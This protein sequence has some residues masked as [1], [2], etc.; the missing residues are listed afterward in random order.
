MLIDILLFVCAYLLGSIPSAVWIGKRFYGVDVREHGSRNA[1]AT[2]TLRVLGAKAAIPV[3]AMDVAKGFLAVQLFRLSPDA[4]TGWMFYIKLS[5]V[6]GVVLGHIFPVF[7]DFRGGKGVATLAGSVLAI[8]PPAV[9]LCILTFAVIFAIT[10]YVSVS[11][12]TA[13]IMSPVYMRF[14]FGVHYRP[15]LIFGCA[16]ALLLIWTHRKNIGR[17][18]SGTESKIRL[19]RK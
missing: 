13:G 18:I 9:L 16:V 19:A 12:M 1:G 5:L 11:S 14:V 8:H 10:H 3:F 17:L 7:A 4:A 2:N 6:I 15:L